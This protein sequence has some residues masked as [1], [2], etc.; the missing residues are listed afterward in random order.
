M[1]NIFKITLIFALIVG[2]LSSCEDELL[3]QVNP[4]AVTTDSFWQTK[5]DFNKATNALYS[6]L[7]F[8]AVSGQG[9]VENMVRS[10]L[11]GSE[12]WYTIVNFSNMIWNDATDNV[13]DRW[14]QLYIGIYRANQ[15]LYYIEDVTFLTDA[16]KESIIAQTRFLR[17]LNYFGLVQSYNQAIIQDVLPIV[18]ADMHKPLSPRAEVI[19]KMVIPDLTYAYEHLPKKW[20]DSGDTGRFTWGAAAAML[21]KTYLYDKDWTNA[22]KYFKEVIDAADND[23]LYALVPNFMDNFTI[24]NE[25]N[26]ESIL[27]VAYSDNYKEGA[28]GNRTDD[29]GTVPGSEASSIASS[30]ASITGAGGYNTCLPTYWLQELFVAG[31]SIDI[32]NP[33]N[34]GYH[35]SQR[36]YAT[37]AVEFGDGDYYQAPLVATET[38]KSKA[39]FTF[40]Q[41]SKVKK[42]TSWY[43][44]ENEDMS[45]GART[46]I[47]FRLIRL[48]DVYLM[49]AET[50]LEGSTADVAGAMKYIDKVRSRAGVIT[51]ESYRADNGGMIPVLDKSRFPN[52][53]AQFDMVALT[54]ESLLHHL[55]MVER[56][57]E[58]AFEGHRWYDLVRWGLIKET[59]TARK[60]EED[61]IKGLLL[62]PVSNAITGPQIFPLYLNQRVR[63]DWAKAAAN[64]NS[65]SH[66][67]F[68][69][70]SIEAQSNREL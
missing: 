46:G 24:E 9:L 25:F 31:D 45:T 62:D 47:N 44:K 57:L 51:L 10:D 5:E 17:G 58:L 69:I 2:T 21:G 43:Y 42:W 48:A 7:Q 14:S 37:L 55:R 34:A 63:P 59:F 66:D 61:L 53:L 3:D 41:G 64:Y 40:G 18:D 12:S 26:S 50:L 39:N 29:I 8:S 49:Y 16:E 36:T 6:S 32:S 22:A 35:Y 30:F 15:I 23:G 38:E 19:S 1:R 68:P 60:A 28:S 4:N 54:K 65:A 11:A 70:P 27:E 67:Y 33:I 13:V 52:G 56:P 20:S